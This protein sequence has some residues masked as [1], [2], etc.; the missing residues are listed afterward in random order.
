MTE[1]WRCTSFYLHCITTQAAGNPISGNLVSETDGRTMS[2][3]GILFPSLAVVKLNDWC[4][5]HLYGVEL[6]LLRECRRPALIREDDDTSEDSVT[7][8]AMQSRYAIDIRE[9]ETNPADCTSQ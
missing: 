3:A 9:T 2:E 7:F 5:L 6:A 4:C 8:V 1:L